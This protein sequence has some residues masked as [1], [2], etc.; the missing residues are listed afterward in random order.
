[1]TQLVQTVET[2]KK[3]SFSNSILLTQIRAIPNFYQ[4]GIA[5]LC[6][7]C[8]GVTV[9]MTKQSLTNLS[10]LMILVIESVSSIIFLW[11]IILYQKV[12]LPK[13]SIA[14]QA[15]LVGF[16]E[17]GLSYIFGTFGLSLTTA[18]NA[19]L[20]TLSE[21]I[22]TI[23]LAVVLLKE[24]IS[25]PLINLA[26][27]ACV[28]IGMVASPNITHITV[29]SLTGDSLVL[30]SVLCASLYAIAARPLMNRVAP[31]VMVALQQSFALVW[32]VLILG[33]SQ[34]LNHSAINL[35]P[36]SFYS[37]SYSIF[38]AVISGIVGQGLA[39]WLY[40]LAL[41]SSGVSVTSLYLTLIPLFGVATAYITLGER[42]SI[43]QTLGGGLI[44]VVVLFISQLPQTKH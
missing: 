18:S 6:A 10:P 41:R 33:L 5:V 25:S 29:N 32:F 9:P 31:L 2:T 12:E 24:K 3:Y 36:A 8:F 13:K 14:F 26:L 28:G 20:I 11:S 15:S 35:A 40:L 38:L 23:A 34:F 30:L 22:I 42:L 16:L 4:V 7:A 1:M 21:P 39:F 43:I 17:P 44:L 37:Y 19:T 27:V